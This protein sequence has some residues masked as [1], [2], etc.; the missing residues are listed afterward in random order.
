MDRMCGFRSAGDY[1][2]KAA[3][4]MSSSDSLMSLSDYQNLICSSAGENHVFGSDEL[5]SAAASAL[6]SEAVSIAPRVRRADQDNNFIKSKIASHP[7][8]P[9][10]LQTYIDCQKVIG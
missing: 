9:R 1:P 2:E 3:L 8:Y 10:L 5:F 4:V 7:L 6:S